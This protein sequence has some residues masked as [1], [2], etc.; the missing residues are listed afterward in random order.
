[1]R[2]LLGSD[3]KNG[4]DQRKAIAAKL[5]LEVEDPRVK[6]IFASLKW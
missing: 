6:T 1:M 2:S 3:L 4:I 5:N